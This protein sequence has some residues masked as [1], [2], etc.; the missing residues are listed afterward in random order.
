MATMALVR[1]SLRSSVPG[2]VRLRRY[3]SSSSRALWASGGGGREGRGGEGRGGEGRGG[4]GRGGEEE[5]ERGGER[6]R[7]GGIRGRSCRAEGV[8]LPVV[9]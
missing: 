1:A 3:S 9:L 6:E 4:K 7:E 8:E 2:P 5:G